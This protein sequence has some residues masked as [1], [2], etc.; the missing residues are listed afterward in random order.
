MRLTIAALILLAICRPRIRGHTT[1]DWLSI[2]AFGIALAG[3][4]T[5]FYQAIDRIPMGAAVT[6]EVLG[7]LTLSVLTARTKKG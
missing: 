1:T 5:L 6:L 4:N 7:P 2:G 3:L